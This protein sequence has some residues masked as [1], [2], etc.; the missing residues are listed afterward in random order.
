M[1][2]STVTREECCDLQHSNYGSDVIYS[3]VTREKCCDLQ[4]SN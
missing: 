4:H 1:I 2:Y 3:T